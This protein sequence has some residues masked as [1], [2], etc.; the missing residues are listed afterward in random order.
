M[1]PRILKFPSQRS[2]WGLK[3]AA[4]EGGQLRGKEEILISRASASRALHFHKHQL[5]HENIEISACFLDVLF[6]FFFKVLNYFGTASIQT[7]YYKESFLLPRYSCNSKL[8]ATLPV[9][10]KDLRKVKD[11]GPCDGNCFL[12]V[13]GTASALH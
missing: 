4:G 2:F 1:T 10:F 6:F 11:P 12:K 7:R 8:F 9:C 13:K 5:C 3:T